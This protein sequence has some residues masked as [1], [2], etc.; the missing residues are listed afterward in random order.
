MRSVQESHDRTV[1]D[2]I[3]RQAHAES[4]WQVQRQELTKRVQA[5]STSKLEVEARALGLAKSLGLRSV[6][7]EV[8]T[9]AAVKAEL[10]KVASER[11]KDRLTAHVARLE[12]QL[13]AA[14]R[15]SSSNA[16]SASLHHSHHQQHGPSN[17]FAESVAEMTDG[18]NKAASRLAA[19]ASS[20]SPPPPLV[21]NQE[22]APAKCPVWALRPLY[23][24]LNPKRVP[25]E[26]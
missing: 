2:L 18:I 12:G 4:E 23:Q 15:S 7:L 25:P 19:S 8:A 22:M 11:E 26:P 14:L 6:D 3:A 13:A 5:L 9:A 17:R 16:R 21:P 1:E 20:F 10:A 24:S